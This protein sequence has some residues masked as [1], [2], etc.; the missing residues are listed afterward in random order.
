MT[1]LSIDKCLLYNLGCFTIQVHMIHRTDIPQ[2]LFRTKCAVYSVPWLVPR[3]RPASCQTVA[4]LL[5][6]QHCSVLAAFGNE[7]I[8]YSIEAAELVQTS[9]QRSV[10]D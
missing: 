4:V 1:Y 8:V 6:E 7:H 3:W 2:I 9:A 10:V 5:V